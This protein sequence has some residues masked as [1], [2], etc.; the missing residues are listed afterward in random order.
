LTAAYDQSCVFCR[1]ARGEVEGVIVY[2][3]PRV[4]ALMDLHPATRGHLLVMPKEHIK[5]IFVVS[6]TLGASIMEVTVRLARA[7]RDTLAPAG[8][9][10][11]QANGAA[12]GQ[13]IGHFH[14]HLVPRYSGDRVTLEFGHGG[15]A[16]PLSDLQRVAALIRAD[17]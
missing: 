10:L 8:L 14:L 17:L 7:L 3:D 15:E 9:N 13:T 1:I 6:E 4:L 5:D 2:Q 12:A 11:I 16:A